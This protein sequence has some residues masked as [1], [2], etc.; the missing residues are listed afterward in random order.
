M[1]DFSLGLKNDFFERELCISDADSSISNS[2]PDVRAAGLPPV[3]ELPDRHVPG[4]GRVRLR[5]GQRVR[6][7]REARVRGD[8]QLRPVRARPL[9]GQ[10]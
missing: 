10:K 1:G 7:G 9:R 3:D 2:T 8:P 6:G 4:R 5:D